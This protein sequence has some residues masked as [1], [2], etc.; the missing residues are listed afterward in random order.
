MASFN[1]VT[2]DPLALVLS[3]K[4]YVDIHLPD[5][6]PDP[7]YIRDLVKA[8]DPE[9]KRL[10]LTRVKALGAYANALEKELSKV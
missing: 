8:L 10:A 9:Q 6:P 7:V 5:P 4:V 1:Y 2:I 3:H